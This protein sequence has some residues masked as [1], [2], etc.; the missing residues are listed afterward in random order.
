MTSISTPASSSPIFAIKIQKSEYREHALRET[1]LHRLIQAE[2]PPHRSS[3]ILS[4]IQNFDHGDQCCMVFEEFGEELLDTVGDE[5]LPL[6]QVKAVAV[7]IL[8][9]IE[10][11]HQLDLIHSDL[12][13]ENILYDVESK[14][15]KLIDFSTAGKELRR[16]GRFGTRAYRAPE[17]L[18][19]SPLSKAIDIW[20]LGCLIYELFVGDYL[21]DP[22][23]EAESGDG[24]ID[25][26]LILP[27]KPEPEGRQL[28]EG[29]ILQGR[30]VLLSVLGS[31]SF[32]TVWRARCLDV[33]QPEATWAC[34]PLPNT[35]AETI[36]TSEDG[37][38]G[39]PRLDA[40]VDLRDL[41]LNRRH[42]S[43]MESMLGPIPSQLEE[44]GCYRDQLMNREEESS[45]APRSLA[46]K[47]VEEEDCP[48]A[49]AEEI[50]SFLLPMLQ[51]DPEARATATECLAHPFLSRQSQSHLSRNLLVASP[52]IASR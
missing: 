46:Q 27:P 24:E 14:T 42:L 25:P 36:S 8:Q 26:D 48:K 5:M 22:Y 31:G 51:L 28:E 50:E 29:D 3:N 40:N 18:L 49:L 44:S 6:A 37:K 23:P 20:A 32:S 9:A 11:L 35:D 15:S 38:T 13:P 7:E 4:P 12:K 10:Q 39:L 41:K 33:A 17:V 21:F 30:F 34:P 16:G 45:G 19:G 2:L 1:R 52:V 47:L 43:L